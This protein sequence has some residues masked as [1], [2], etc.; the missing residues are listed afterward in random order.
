MRELERP[1]LGIVIVRQTL[2]PRS[3]RRVFF[4]LRFLCATVAV[5][6]RG[7][8]ERP[9]GASAVSKRVRD[10]EGCSETETELT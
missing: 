3:N 10:F 7:R 4:R 8:R 2:Q 9:I 5:E 6:Q 1:T